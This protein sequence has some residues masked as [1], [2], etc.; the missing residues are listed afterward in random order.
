MIKIFLNQID[1]KKICN[2][3]EQDSQILHYIRADKS[4]GCKIKVRISRW[5]NVKLTLH[6]VPFIQT[7]HILF[8]LYIYFVY[9][10]QYFFDRLE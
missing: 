6:T 8:T 3:F 2:W 10:I 9:Y 5:Y 4:I 1:G 7:A